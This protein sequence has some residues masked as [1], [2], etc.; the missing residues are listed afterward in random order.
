MYFVTK[1]LAFDQGQPQMTA[2]GYL[3][4]TVL[5]GNFSGIVFIPPVMAL[6]I[7]SSE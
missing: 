7:P 2:T 4:I 1:V 3:V 6:T 5:P